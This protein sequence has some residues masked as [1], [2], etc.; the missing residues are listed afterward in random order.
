MSITH[1][2][3]E[4]TI[5]SHEGW[6]NVADK[7][8]N[9]RKDWQHKIYYDEE[10]FKNYHFNIQINNKQDLLDITKLITE[11]STVYPDIQIEWICKIKEASIGFSTKYKNFVRGQVYYSEI[12]SKIIQDFKKIKEIVKN[13]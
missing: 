7:W 1:V 5:E 3:L 4:C 8:S 2:I 10:D 9:L 12:D 11:L 6:L 13:Y